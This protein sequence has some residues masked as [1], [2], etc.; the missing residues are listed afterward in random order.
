MSLRF[1]PPR[2]AFTPEVRWML[3]RAF[4][5]AGAPFPQAIGPAAA[6]ATARRFELSARIAARQGRAPLSRELGAETADG[7]ARDRA[8]AAAV[9][10]RLM[11]AARR[12]AEQAA[13]L[14][15][16][17]T[18]L[19][20]VALEATGRLAPGS[21]DACDVDALAPESQAGELWQALV[22]AGFR[23]SALPA[24]EHQLPALEDAEAGA[25]EIH[26]SLPGVRLA[27]GASATWEA[28]DRQRLLVALPDF[29]GR[30][31]A[32]AP[33]VQ[34]AHVAVHGLAQH[35]WWPSSYSLLRMAADLIDLGALTGRA[36]T[37]VA[38]D[39]SA[40]EGEA[41]RRL[42]SR[43]AAGEDPAAGWDEPEETL[44]R[45]M[46]AGRLDAEYERSLRLGLF[47]AQPSDRPRAVRLARSVLSTVFL[48][49]AQIDAIYGPPRS[50]LGYLGRRIARPF[51]LLLRLG[52]YGANWVRVQR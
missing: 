7:F 40:A 44:L 13:L 4:G 42:C 38:R 23:A 28:L 36:L 6:L 9:G 12:I 11:A 37:W 8:T 16:P 48:S 46:L 31:S 18:F 29:P 19:K 15:V 35:G 22:A 45:H 43:L 49:D 5:P 21:R 32:P 51:D 50:R 25:V 2:L 20:F 1:H 52:R 34:A 27:A 39:V 26:R 17:I 14:G 3:L 41:L 24:P 33:E 30:C 10:M 47:R